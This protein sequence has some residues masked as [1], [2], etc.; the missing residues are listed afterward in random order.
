[1]TETQA[2]QAVFSAVVDLDIDAVP[3]LVQTALQMGVGSQTLLSQG[4]AAGVRVVGERYENGEYYLTDLVLAGEVMKAGLKELNPTLKPE[5]SS[6]SGKV[7][8]ATVEGDIHEIGKNLVGVMLSAAGFEVMDL[9]VNVPAEQIVVAAREHRADI[10]GLSVL[11]TPMIG[12]LKAVLDGL[13]EAGLRS[14]TKVVIGG[15]CTTPELANQLGVDAHGADAVAAVRIC[16]RLLGAIA[17][18]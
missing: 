9:G 10:V 3:G 11:L 1:M 2:I 16:Q 6:L 8:L 17:T 7:I 18:P 13:S 14:T 15:A 5:E 12:Q 4:L